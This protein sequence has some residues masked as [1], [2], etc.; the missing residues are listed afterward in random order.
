MENRKDSDILDSP[1]E[2]LNDF[3]SEI[4]EAVNA[5]LSGQVPKG[6]DP[7]TPIQHPAIAK[8]VSEHRSDFIDDPAFAYLKNTP[9]GQP[10][11]DTSANRGAGNRN[12]TTVRRNAMGPKRPNEG[13]DRTSSTKDSTM[14]TNKQDSTT[15]GTATIHRTE[16]STPNQSSGTKKMRTTEGQLSVTGEG[17]SATEDNGNENGFKQNDAKGSGAKGYNPK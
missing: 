6:V 12:K 7:N 16:P 14:Q 9:E 2:A 13:K 5:F 15:E 8:Y 17:S 1:E 11:N 10:A 3:S 4:G